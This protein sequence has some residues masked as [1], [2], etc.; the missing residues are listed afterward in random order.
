MHASSK[1]M[2]LDVRNVSHDPLKGEIFP[3]KILILIV[4]IHSALQLKDGALLGL[5]Q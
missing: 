3:P 4:Y 5:L 2:L 1:M